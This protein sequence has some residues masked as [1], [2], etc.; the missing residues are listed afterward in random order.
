[1]KKLF[2]VLFLMS[3]FLFIQGV[4]AQLKTPDASPHSIVT[5]DVGL[6]EITITYSRPGVKGREVFGGLVPYDKVWRTG[7]NAATT[8]EFS[9]DVMIMGK[10]LKAGKY[11]LYTIPREDKWTVIFNED[12]KQWGAFNFKDGDNAVSVEVEPYTISPAMETFTIGINDIRNDQA[13]IIL[14]WDETAVKV[15][16]SV[17]T[18]KKVMANIKDVMDGP[19]LRDYYQAGS[20]YYSEGKNLEKALEWVSI[21]VKANP[22]YYSVHKKALILGA[23]GRYDDA[24]ATAKES[25]ELAKKAGDDHYLRLNTLKIKEWSKK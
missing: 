25:I 6:T 9:D 2:L 18:D 19:S 16:F 22:Q 3:G 8:V 5:Q 23:L 12:W 4:D 14:K 20:Y 17:P 1:M 24:I 15:P 11:S 10:E 7:A 13:A 21:A